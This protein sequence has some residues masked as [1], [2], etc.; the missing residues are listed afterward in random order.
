MLKP[1]QNSETDRV[2]RVIWKLEEC[3]HIL[4][5]LSIEAREDG[6]HNDAEKYLS[7]SL[8]IEGM[9]PSDEILG[10][11]LILREALARE[12]P[13]PPQDSASH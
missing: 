9:I 8:A 5:Q 7:H 11:R 4:V 10:L 13:I 3:F 12:R 2:G 1:G 6:R